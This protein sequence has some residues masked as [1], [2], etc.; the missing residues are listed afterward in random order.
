MGHPAEDRGVRR[1]QSRAVSLPHAVPALIATM[2]VAIVLCAGGEYARRAVFQDIG[3]LGVALNDVQQPLFNQKNQGSVLQR[4]A[5][6]RADLLPIYGSSELLNSGELYHARVLFHDYAVG[7]DL[8]PVAREGAPILSNLLKLSTV[9]SEVKGAKVVISISPGLFLDSMASPEY[10][11]G[12][13]SALQAGELA[14]SGELS[15]AVKRA[16]ARRMLDY[17]QTLADD[18]FLRMTLECLSDDSVTASA[19]YA[20][21]TP[22]GRMR[23]QALRLQD[24]LRTFALI[25]EA[26]LSTPPDTE[27]E[28]APDWDSLMIRAERDYAPQSNNNVFGF[29]N[30]YWTQKGSGIVALAGSSSDEAFTQKLN[31]SKSWTDL[32]LLLQALHEQ[33]AEPLVIS[34]PLHGRY[35]EFL[36]VSRTARAA[37]YERLRA[38]T[39]S[40]GAALV[41]FADHEDDCAFSTDQWGHLS[42]KG[43]VA[44]A[45]VLDEFHRG[46]LR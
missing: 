41:D 37:Y 20:A 16:A 36:G 3:T 44:Y 18:P 25:G 17:P 7:F 12:S 8:F 30:T 27:D 26:P 28:S 9:G 14:F 33:G 31:T 35:Y 42:P 4:A 22:V 34:S 43:W 10:Y 46:A 38:L 40:N 32:D 24:E 13:Y 2:L 15:P 23:N 45:K 39:Q 1:G 29:W 11:G 5:F 19:C 6:N 21:L